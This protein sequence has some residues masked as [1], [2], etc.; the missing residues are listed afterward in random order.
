MQHADTESH[1]PVEPPEDLC[2][3]SLP[4]LC[5]QLQRAQLLLLWLSH[6]RINAL[7]VELFGD[8][9]RHGI[10]GARDLF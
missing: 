6:G 3:A 9:R 4:D 1:A 7:L 2:K 8:A 5:H 10:R